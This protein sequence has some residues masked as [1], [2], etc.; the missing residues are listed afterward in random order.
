MRSE[1]AGLAPQERDAGV[2][3]P[4][5]SSG[6]ELPDHGLLALANLGPAGTGHERLETVLGGAP[7]ERGDPRARHQRLGRGAPDVDAGAADVRALDDGRPA[8]RPGQRHRQRH[9]CLTGA[10]HERVPGLHRH[11]T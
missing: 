7:R 8:I 6:A 10:D 9:A 11:R 2:P 3:E 4:P 5:L 1:E